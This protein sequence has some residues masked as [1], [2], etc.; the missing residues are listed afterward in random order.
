MKLLQKTF[1]ALPTPSALTERKH[2]PMKTKFTRTPTLEVCLT[3]LLFLAAVSA[4]FG[5]PVITQQPLNQTNCQGDTVTFSV[6]AT[7][8]PPL[9][10]QWRSHS[11]I[12]S[13]T[14]MPGE[15]NAVL[16]L[17]NVLKTWRY[18]VVVSDATTLSVTSALVRVAVNFPFGITGQP[19]GATL[20]VGSTFTCS[21]VVSNSTSVTYQWYFND[22]P[23]AGKTIF[24][25]TITNIQPSDAGDYWVVVANP[26]CGSQT[27]QTARLDVVHF[28]PGF[29]QQPASVDVEIGF[30]FTCSVLATGSPPL[31]YQWYFQGA[32]LPGKTITNLFF[33]SFQSSNSGE[34]FVVVTNVWGAATSQ[35]AT[36]KGG[37]AKF[38]KITTGPVVTDLGASP[39][40]PAWGD[41][42]ND[43][44]V[45][46]VILDGFYN[47]GSD[48]Q[49]AVPMIYLN[50]RDGTF[51]RAG[52]ADIGPLA[53][54]LAMAQPFSLADYDN[55]GYL[56]VY[57]VDFGDPNPEKAAYLYHGGADGRFTLMSE[58]VG[59]NRPLSPW[60]PAWNVYVVPWGVSWVDYDRDGFLDVYMST[61]WAEGNSA[62]QLWRNNG[63]GTFSRVLTNVF[64]TVQ[65]SQFSCWADCDNDGDPDLFLGAY[66]GAGRFY[67]NDG[68]GQ[69]TDLTGSLGLVMSIHAAWG[70]YD[71]DGD[72]DLYTSHPAFYEN[73]GTGHFISKPGPA[74]LGSFMANWI[75][76]D[77][78]GY[79]DWFTFYTTSGSYRRLLLRNNRDGTFSEVTGG[80]L[81]RDPA[82]S[83]ASAWADYDNDGFL[84][85]VLCSRAR[86]V[87]NNLYHNN[88]N[89]N[90][91]LLVKL[92]GTTSN[93]S[94]IGAKVRVY[95]T[96]W[97]K[98][99][100]QMREISGTPIVD[101]L[102]AHF[103]LGDTTNADLVR[104]EWPSRQVTELRNVASKQILTITEPPGL[105]ILGKT[106]ER[107]DLRVTAHPG[108]SWGISNCTHL[109]GLGEPC[110]S[111]PDTNGH[112]QPVL[113][114]TNASR[115][116]TVSDTNCAGA[117][118]RFYK[119]AV[120]K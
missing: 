27:S 12:A 10:Y 84:D 97:G 33:S 46:L 106:P 108:M 87:P 90:H 80:P 65:D 48:Y 118:I 73:D 64:N 49:R 29:T 3:V 105:Q 85:V 71:N 51:R 43:G 28:P 57:L 40:C 34:Y 8:A 54:Q 60:M 22:Q 47:S 95:A 7:G 50:N 110:P 79:L 36:L 15:T 37:P 59:V 17:T 11:S 101:D 25:L 1:Q 19:A 66:A 75:D 67:R 30:P 72:L 89:T 24:G 38:T 44:Y 77:N 39:L 119:A 41:L 2:T 9:T 99:L 82:S 88:G 78:D 16:V 55:D 94:A 93:R 92:V 5:Q 102:R 103:G 113:S 114:G 56:D 4:G 21:V 26:W 76:Y 109:H 116:V 68:N 58:D 31:F 70:D 104:I 13:F 91:W 6:E 81:T 120:T 62:D 20:E 69:F 115:T 63:N 23:L 53:T 107:L 35:V 18:A 42:N 100:Q 61:G 45:D 98:P 96:I 52:E 32:A 14:N 83:G 74:A 111:C 117:S 86:N 112:W